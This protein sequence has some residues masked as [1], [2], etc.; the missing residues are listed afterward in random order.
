[1]KLPIYMDNHA[2]TPLDPRVLEAMMPYFTEKFG[3]AA[4]KSHVFGWEAEAAVEKARGQIARLLGASPEEIIFTS[5]A[6]ESNNIALTG[7]FEARGEKEASFITCATEHK[8]VL[9]VCRSLEKKGARLTCLP[10]EREGR[11]NLSELKKALS[12]SPLLVSLMAAN[13]E[14][15]TLHPLAEIG[16]LARE[17]GVLFHTDAAQA[18][19]KIPIDVESMRIDLLSASAHKLYGPKGVGILYVR[20]SVRL[21]VAALFQGGGH[22]KGL[23]SGT[24]NAPAIVGMGKACEITAEEMEDENR[25]IS[26]LRDRLYETIIQGLDEVHLNGPPLKQRLAQNL[27]VSFPFVKAEALIMEMKEVALSSGSACTSASPHPSHVIKALGVSDEEVR[28]SLRFGLGRFNTQEEVDY[29]A[30]RVVETVKKIRKASPEYER[31]KHFASK[32]MRR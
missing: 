8:A 3:N 30:Q 31:E 5:G 7:V 12:S 14:I 28:S 16:A 11:M 4:S 21:K 27:N 15:G 20:K 25:R 32:K 17:K 23:R 2:T 24:L 1:M 13:N 22:E 9:D 18:L 19:G 29:V 26:S 10:V 6:T